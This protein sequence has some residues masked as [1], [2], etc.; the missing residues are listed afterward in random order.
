[1]FAFAL[2]Q[3]AT[4]HNHSFKLIEICRSEWSGAQRQVHF[5]CVYR[6][7]DGLSQT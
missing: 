7:V 3:T 6:Y 4:T 2:A 1:M 5:N